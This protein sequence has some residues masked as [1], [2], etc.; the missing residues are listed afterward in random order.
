MARFTTFSFFNAYKLPLFV[1]SVK[2]LFNVTYQHGTLSTS[3]MIQYQAEF[4]PKQK[5]VDATPKAE[6]NQVVVAIKI[7][8]CSGQYYQVLK[9]AT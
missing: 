5:Q 7:M 2:R 4:Q 8:L 3:T 6:P 1:N 9:S